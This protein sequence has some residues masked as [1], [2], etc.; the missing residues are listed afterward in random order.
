MGKSLIQKNLL[1]L[2]NRMFTFK[3]PKTKIELNYVLVFVLIIFILYG[4]AST[5]FVCFLFVF[6]H[7]LSHYFT[8]LLLGCEIERMELNLWG[9]V[10]HLKNYVIKPSHEM[11][12]LIAGPSSNLLF[13]LIF[14]ILPKYT[15]TNFI[16][17]IILFNAVLGLFNLMPIVPLDGGKI[18]RLYLTY[19]LGYG[20]AIKIT[21]FFSKIFSIFLL[22]SG[23]YLLQYDILNM[24]ICFV[25]LNI[26][27]SS[28][29]ESNFVLYKIMRYMDII[30]RQM[31]SNRIVVYKSNKKIKHALDSFIPSKKRIFTIVNDK[32]KYRGQL[33]ES[34]LLNGILKYGIYS[35]FKKILELK[36]SNKKEL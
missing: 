23:I 3:I 4:N 22:I 5:F 33:S 29:R 31:L 19:F 2:I 21:L 6:L 13:A 25:A 1:I 27:I 34:D 28:K 14:N 26:Y 9:G 30:D 12:I 15:Q 35:D 10:L 32:G 36:K 24:V 16:K 8:A 11:L 18:I 20:K 17:E 7:E